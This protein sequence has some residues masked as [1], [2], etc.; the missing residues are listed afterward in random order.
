[1][2]HRWA[3]W[4]SAFTTEREY[5]SG[6]AGERVGGYILREL[7]GRGATGAVWRAAWGNAP[8]DRSLDVAVKRLSVPE[9][10]PDQERLRREA[11]ALARLDHPNIIRVREVIDDGP[12]IA[13]VLDLADSGTLADRLRAEGPLSTSEVQRMLGPIAS[14]LQAAHDAGLVHRDVKPA[15]VFLTTAGHALL[16]DFGI[17]HDAARTQLTRTDLAI[18][19]AAY[20]DPEVLNGADPGPAS[21]Q[22]AF[23]VVL[24]EALTGKTP[25]GGA[26]PMAILRAADEGQFTPLDRADFGPLA[27]VVE[28]AF[29]RDPNARFASMTSLAEFVA[30]P[31]T[32]TPSTLYRFVDTSSEG[33]AS[34]DSVLRT[35]AFRR[36]L[37]PD[38]LSAATPVPSPFRKR[39]AIGGAIA[40]LLVAS[41][42]GGVV[43]RSRRASGVAEPTALALPTC[44]PQ[45]QPQCVKS[46]IRTPTGV[47]V[48]FADQ[49]TTE[50]E[51][52]ERDDAL[53][54][55]N[56]LCGERATLAL[57]RPRTGVVYYFDRWPDP[58]VNEPVSIVADQTGVRNAEALVAS[59]RNDDGCADFALQVGRTRTWFLP[60]EQTGRL[61][62]LP[63]IAP[64]PTLTTSGASS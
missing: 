24:Y 32:M 49:R 16:G 26:V 19:T 17:A 51:V 50:Y 53:R 52:G 62:A 44:S 30:E 23:G 37:H 59:D 47:E 9:S 54:V 3:I 41:A 2:G 34:T 63:A 42:I 39:A 8:D 15:N 64:S 6:V 35:T 11:T 7:I 58:R 20:L 1:M 18:G 56:W 25:F 45:T 40:A 57:Y 13:L 12:G 43:L 55:S 31:T 21:D 60:A 4:P 36:R 61:E 29:A 5:K 38:T 27:E 28:R 48:K 22:Y 10:E 14:A 33:A 46:F